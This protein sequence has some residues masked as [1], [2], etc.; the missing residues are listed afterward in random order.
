MV[1]QSHRLLRPNVSHVMASPMRPAPGTQAFQGLPASKVR[2]EVKPRRLPVTGSCS[3][4]GLQKLK[5]CAGKSPSAL[6]PHPRRSLP[7]APRSLARPAA[8]TFPVRAGSRAGQGPLGL[9]ASAV[10]L[11]EHG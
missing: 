3:E 11:V 2:L 8:E 6:G 10:S 9:L 4:W 1:T 5:P 7:V